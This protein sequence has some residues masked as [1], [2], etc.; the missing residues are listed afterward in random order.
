VA[1]RIDRPVVRRLVFGTAAFAV[2]A[3]AVVATQVRLDWLHP[4]MAA[5][6]RR[7]PTIE[8]IDWAPLRDDLAA[9]NLLRPGTIVGV[10]NWRDAGKIAYALGADV[11]TVCLNRD[12]RQFGLS[13]PAA[14]FVGG[15][16]LILALDHPERVDGDLARSFASL[17]QLPDGAIRHA[18]RTL[19]PV[20]VFDARHLLAWPPP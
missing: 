19:Q 7:D 1:S 2:V 4:V 13:Y 8:A 16:L 10:P 20:A 15:D 3:V 11:T 5:F 18:G 9:R 12:C 6:A 14:Q 17:A